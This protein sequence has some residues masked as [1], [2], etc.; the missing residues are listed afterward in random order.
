M[1]APVGGSLSVCTSGLARRN[2][3]LAKSGS[4]LCLVFMNRSLCDRGGMVMD[5]AQIESRTNIEGG[6]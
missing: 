2:E 3:T 5:N 4:L 1:C 6:A